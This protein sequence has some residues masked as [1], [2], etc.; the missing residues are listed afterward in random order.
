MAIMV[1]QLLEVL[2]GNLAAAVRREVTI[3]K[4]GT[5]RFDSG[6]SRAAARGEAKQEQEQHHGGTTAE[7]RQQQ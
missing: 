7:S 6:R 2:T 5:E 1:E 4:D 3:S